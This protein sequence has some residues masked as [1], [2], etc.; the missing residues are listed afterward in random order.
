M[1]EPPEPPAGLGARA[2]ALWEG[3][4]S[5]YALRIDE[6][7]VLEQACRQVDLIELLA[8]EVAK[9]EMIVRGAY[10]QPTAQPLITEIRQHRGTLAALL[11]QLKLPD[12]PRGQQNGLSVSEQARRAANKRWGKNPSGA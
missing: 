5:K 8:A 10:G 1:T 2:A 6:E 3:V 4:T 12:E 9:V 7:Y 11:R